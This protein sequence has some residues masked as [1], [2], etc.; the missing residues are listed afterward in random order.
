MR[1]LIFLHG[2]AIMHPGAVGRTREERVAQ[3]RTGADPALHDYAAYV[4]VDNAV[5]K[6]QHWR[7]QGA[8]ID[9]LSSHRNPDD[10]AKDASV[11]QKYGFPSGRVLAREPGESYGEVAGREMPDI[12]IEDD[13]ESINGAGKI[14][15]P[16]I[17]PELRA[18]IKSIIVPEFCGI[19]HLPD[20][21][22]AL[23]TLE[24]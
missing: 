5:A 12:L 3:V 14:T 1:L 2:T 4:P 8:K 19:D 11:L 10:V 24:P 17:R 9:Y 23:L 16:Q 20:S 22:Q 21:L 15:Y 6:L 18:R 13:C 7:E